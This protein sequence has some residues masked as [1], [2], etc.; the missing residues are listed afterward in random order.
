MELAENVQELGQKE[1]ELSEG[2]PGGQ[3]CKQD[4]SLNNEQAKVMMK[5]DDM[6]VLG[7]VELEVIRVDLLNQDHVNVTKKTS[8]VPRRGELAMGISKRMDSLQQSADKKV[9]RRVVVAGRGRTIRKRMEGAMEVKRIEDFFD[10]TSQGGSKN[11]NKRK[12]DGSAQESARNM[13]KK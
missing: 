8:D 5:T 4:L 10:N 11:N 12:V 9:E 7:R 6:K 13:R 2:E 1:P 3:Q